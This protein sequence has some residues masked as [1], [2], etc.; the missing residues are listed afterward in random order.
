MSSSDAYRKSMNPRM[1][2]ALHAHHRGFHKQLT[3]LSARL[4]TTFDVSHRRVAL[5]T[6]A[7]RYGRRRRSTGLRLGLAITVEKRFISSLR[8]E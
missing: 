5:F 1:S 7:A 2:D 4:W 6:T 8:G 3:G